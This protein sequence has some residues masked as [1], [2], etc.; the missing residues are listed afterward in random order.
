L[1]EFCLR[2]ERPLTAMQIAQAVEGKA[3]PYEKQ[4]DYLLRKG[5]LV[6]P[7]GGLR[8]A[9]AFHKAAVAIRLKH[10]GQDAS[11][12]P[13]L[14]L[15]KSYDQAGHS[16]LA[17]GVMQS[18]MQGF[19]RSPDWG[20]VAVMRMVYLCKAKQWD[21][22]CQEFPTYDGDQRCRAH[23]SNLLYL[24]WLAHARGGLKEKAEEIKGRLIREHPGSILCADMHFDS[25]VQAIQEGRIQEAQRLLEIIEYRFPSSSLVARAK[26]LKKGLALVESK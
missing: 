19:P 13:D 21:T 10:A 9:M 18:A 12:R 26:E 20:S 6:A 22:A 25:A 7:A 1:E 4:L 24:G 2:Q 5:Q 16:S 15:A 14:D 23:A 8:F 11:L 17:A 3:W